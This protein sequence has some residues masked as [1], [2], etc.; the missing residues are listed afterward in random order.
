MADAEQ[1]SESNSAGKTRKRA[2]NPQEWVRNKRKYQ[3]N[4]GKEYV[5]S[6]SSGVERKVEQT[7]LGKDCDCPLKCFARV[8]EERRSEILHGFWE[9]G[10][11]NTQNSYIC[12]S[13]KTTVVQKGYGR[14]P[15]SSCNSAMK[16]FFKIL[17]C[18]K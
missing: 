14:R 7:R 15:S 2:K 12:G 1:S 6:N 5:T 8:S 16:K 17:L 18:Q 9:L 13:V 10:D 3:R 4:H 11:W